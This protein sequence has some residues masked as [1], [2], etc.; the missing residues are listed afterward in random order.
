MPLAPA[1][2]STAG[3]HGRLRTE[4][5]QGIRGVEREIVLHGMANKHSLFIKEY[6][7]V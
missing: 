6:I 1:L 2:Q 4:G 5:G 7:D 3:E